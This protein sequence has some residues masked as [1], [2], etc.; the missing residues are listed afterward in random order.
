MTDSD[1]SSVQAEI[2]RLHYL[3]GLSIRAIARRLKVARKTVRGGLGRRPPAANAETGRRPSLLDGYDDLI[4]Q[5]L[6]DTPELNATQV[7]ERLRPHGYTGGISILRER[8]RRLRPLR[9]PKAYLTVVH[10]P[11]SCVQVDWGDFGF[12]LPGVPRRVSAF[13][14]LMAYSR[15]LYL[16]FVLSQAMGSFLRCMDRALESFGGVTNADVFDNMKT[17]VLENRPDMKPRFNE[18]FLAYA[19]VRGGFAVIAC[20]PGHPEGK[21]GVERGVRTVRET[22]WPGR[23]FRDL[24]DLNSQAIDWRDRIHNRR[25]NETT[26][27]VPSLVF[28]HDER[29]HLKEIPSLPFDT[30]DVD[31]EIVSPTFRVRFDR[32]TYSAPWHLQGQH[33]VVRGND[34]LVRVFLG[35]KCVATHERSW[36]TG[37][38]V[39]D[40]SHPR[41]LREFRRT[42]P[43]DAL[44]ARFGD[45]GSAYFDIMS[46]GRR[47]LR[48]ELLRLTYLA[49]LFTTAQTRSAMQT[50]MRSGH[51]GVE[52]VEFVLRHKRRLE[53]AYTP[54]ELGN[55]ALDGIVL[56]EPDLSIYDPPMFTRDPGGPEED[57][58]EG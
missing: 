27:K 6:L 20:T 25:P 23:R 44:V 39:E 22:F 7:L 35:P 36:D 34:Q 14:A 33:V 13:I 24:A 12:A 53:P 31:H 40:P 52:Y 32:N 37:V 8:V 10:Q 1:G 11:G 28:E 21:G 50:V 19:N 56:R 42:Q 9:A 16:E 55:P 58:H 4:Q 2:M 30:D 3:E 49:E 41:D 46:A 38:D 26:G 51:V 47:S 57:D 18:R 29:L 48:R 43:K 5:L 17:V 15:K 54:L 45:V